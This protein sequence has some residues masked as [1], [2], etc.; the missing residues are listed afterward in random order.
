MKEY[1]VDLRSKKQPNKGPQLI[2][3]TP[4]HSRSKVDVISG[5]NC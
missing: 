4:K 5:K 2:L 3:K 1:F